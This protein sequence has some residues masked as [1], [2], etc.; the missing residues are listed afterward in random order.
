MTKL[1]RFTEAEMVEAQDLEAIS[2]AAREGDE[3][4]TGGAIGYPLH[5]ADFTVETPTAQTIRVNE[6]RLFEDSIVYDL[7]ADVTVDLLT[8]LPTVIGDQR[9]VAIL[10]RG[11]EQ[12]V[13]DTRFVE[14]DV[15]TGETS[16]TAVPKTVRRTCEF[17]VQQGL[18]SP[19]P[20]K[21]VVADSN[22]C[23]CFVRLGTSGII[24][25][26]SSNDH[27]VKTLYEVEGRVT[28]LEAQMVIAF[29]RTT[30]LQTDLANLQG[31]L[32]DFARRIA[33][34]QLQEDMARV[35]RIVN[36]PDTARA[37]F[38][39]P[40]LIKAQWALSHAQWDARVAEGIRFPRAA[41]AN[42]PLAVQNPTQTGIRIKDNVLM[43]NWVEETR[44]EVQGPGSSKN[45]SQQVHTVTTPIQRSVARTSVSYGPTVALC[46]NTSEYSGFDAAAEG[47]TF[48]KAGE[49]FEKVAV[50]DATFAGDNI[51]LD[52]FNATHG[53]GY[54]LDKVVLHNSEVSASGNRQI[55]AAR[56]VQV[57][58][59][60]ETYTDYV[61]ETFGING[62]IYG[63]SFLLTQPM[64]LTSIDVNFERVGNDGAVTM[65]LCDVSST[66]EPLFDSVIARTTVAHGNLTT[67]WT[68]FEF[69]P[70]YL[71]PGK[72]YAWVTVTTGNHSL[73]T[74]TGSS[75]TQGS[76]FWSTDGAWFQ[77]SNEEDFWFRLNG[78]AHTD[79]RAQVLFNPLTLAGGMSELRLLYESWSPEGTGMIWE[80]RETGSDPW[81]VLQPETTDV[82]NALRGLPETCQLR[83]TMIGTTGLSPAIVL[84]EN[85]KAESHRHKTT[86]VG[87]TKVL[88]FGLSTTS[89]DVEIS[90]DQWVDA[91]HAFVPKVMVGTTEYTA[92]AVTIEPDIQRPSR[93]IVKADFTVPSTTEARLKFTMTTGDVEYVYF[94][95]NAS[96][97]AN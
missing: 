28:I 51:N 18:P 46:G 63:Q 71:A 29:A 2:A 60:T 86:G 1:V 38:Y 77:G 96:L 19:T 69:T 70:R 65:V 31:R 22:C 93:R 21:P 54:D 47:Q 7:D 15:D 41:S 94:V 68:K 66:G 25:V 59:W 23:L 8:H 91:E 75:F 39:D 27:R 87:I 34:R 80:V 37:Y 4:L 78:A 33:V 73:R 43:I 95:E 76:L 11:V 82:P 24:A 6:G 56:S 36:L 48:Q 89:I 13:T 83:L 90:L 74:V 85:A 67:G 44:V 5:W 50:I 9:Y 20:L 97:Y 58:S 3:N 84:N 32:K 52:V 62:S 79:V 42:I 72:R 12:T 30:T 14:T 53:G 55:F 92:N 88:Q 16:P 57:D 26:E 17:V 45:I 81:K 40:G 49:T 10:V 35:R 61:T 64:T